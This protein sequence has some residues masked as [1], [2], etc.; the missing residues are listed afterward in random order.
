ME[1][2]YKT[3][4]SLIDFARANVR[5]QRYRVSIKDMSTGEI[6]LSK[7]TY[8]FFSDVQ[9][10]FWDYSAQHNNEFVL[11]YSV[12]SIPDFTRH[13]HHYRGRKE[14]CIMV[15]KLVSI[16][17]PDHLHLHNFIAS[18][19]RPVDSGED[20]SIRDNFVADAFSIS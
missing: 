1:N 11:D 18:D 17:N 13:G 16:V 3:V 9:K 20:A 19:S 2:Q 4:A 10:L 5:D 12:V 6:R 7:K 14:L 15:T 8:E